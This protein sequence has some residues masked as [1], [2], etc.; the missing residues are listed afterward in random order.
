MQK[1]ELRRAVFG[2]ESCIGRLPWLNTAVLVYVG[3][4]V[5]SFVLLQIAPVLTWMAKTP[6]YHISTYLGLIGA[7]LMAL[8]LFT[9]RG[10]WRGIWCWLLYGVAFM[11]VIASLRTMR[12]GVKDNLFDL[13][14][15]VIQFALVYSLAQRVGKE[16]MRRFL[17][18]LFYV[19][20]VIW[21]IACCVGLYQYLFRI[22]YTYVANPNTTS[23]ELTRQGYYQSRLFGLFMGLDYAAYTSMFLFVGCMQGVVTRGKHWAGRAALAVAAL[24]LVTHVILSV[25]RSALIALILYAVCFTVLLVRNRCGSM[26]QLKR[27]GVSVLAVVCAVVV[28]W[29]C[30][31]GIRVG[32]QHM[33]VGTVIEE[34]DAIERSQEGDVSN[35]RFEIWRDYLSL[36]G[37]IGPAGLSLSNYN[38]YIGDR[39][40]EMYIVRYFTDQFKDT[41]K[42]DLVYESHNNYLFV[43]ISTGFVGAGLFLCFLVLVLVRVIRYILRH[44]QLSLWTITTLAVVA[45]G[46]VEALF[47]NSVFLKINDVS[48]IFWLALGALMLETEDKVPAAERTL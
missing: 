11:D 44:P 35:N 40:P 26:K 32:M 2:D 10:L 16:R 38:D 17:R 8:D 14:W 5:V 1:R 7:V 27:L 36:A 46:L 31:E 20:L 43:F 34:P 42:T 3:V 47:M 37:E 24:V 45:F 19:V 30:T 29:G 41:V 23:P 22:G 18:N 6:L 15:V 39:H 21:G 48:F 12:Y 28:C 33:A 25:S 9:N 13:C 4:T